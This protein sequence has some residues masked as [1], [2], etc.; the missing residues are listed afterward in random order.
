MLAAVALAAWPILRPS[1]GRLRLTVLDVG[2]GDAI[3]VEAPDGRVLLVDG[4][5][6]GP[7]RLDI[8]ERVVAPY[9]WNRGHLRLGASVVT[10][11]DAD[12]AGGMRAV[13]RLF[14]VDE[15][16][17]AETLARG[18]RWIGGAM[19]TLVRLREPRQAGGRDP[20]E[21][22]LATNPRANV[23]GAL[24]PATPRSYGSR[25]GPGPPPYRSLESRNNEAIVL[26]IELGLA[27]FLLA[28]DIEAAREQALVASGAPLAATVLKVP[29]H[30]SRTSSTAEFLRAVRPTAAVISV[31]ARNPYTHPDAGVL[32]RLAAAGARLY[33]TDRDGAVIFETDGRELTV[34][35]WATRA[36]ERFCLDPEA[37]C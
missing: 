32:E 13:R 1:D 12:H 23:S 4:G 18:P 19:I 14:S 21:T 17:D 37:I 20:S 2:Q 29:H 6:A 5:P 8:G 24:P 33:R 31:G 27:S 16:W 22:T 30:G 28:S 7:M 9:L 36:V 35:R 11:D 10:H 15:T 3:V 34:T 26:R 25:R